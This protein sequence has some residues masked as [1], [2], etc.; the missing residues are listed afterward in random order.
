MAYSL[1]WYLGNLDESDAR[2]ALVLTSKSKW[3]QATTPFW[4]RNAANA[5]TRNFSQQMRLCPC[6]ADAGVHTERSVTFCGV[7]VTANKL[8][9]LP[10]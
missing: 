8:T 1:V 7:T 6:C 3:P 2:T 5:Y 9:N 4:W 10:I